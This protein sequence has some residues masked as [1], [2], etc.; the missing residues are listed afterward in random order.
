MTFGVGKLAA[1][2]DFVRLNSPSRRDLG[3]GESLFC[4]TLAEHVSMK[5]A[6]FAVSGKLLSLNN[7]QHWVR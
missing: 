7:M 1:S 4:R 2:R 5:I 3:D 6:A